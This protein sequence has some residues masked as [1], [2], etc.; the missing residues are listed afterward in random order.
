MEALQN[1]IRQL[2]TEAATK[3][4]MEQMQRR[5]D[6]QENDRKL[7]QLNFKFDKREAHAKAI[8]EADKREAQAKAEMDKREGQARCDKLE[9]NAKAE[10]EKR[11][12]QARCDKLEAMLEKEKVRAR[13]NEL[14]MKAKMDK[15]QAKAKTDMLEAAFENEKKDRLQQ[16]ISQLKWEARLGQTPQLMYSQPPPPQ[17]VYGHPPPQPAGHILANPAVLAPA[18]ILSTP[19]PIQQPI[20]GADSDS[21]V[22]RLK[23]VREMEKSNHPALSILPPRP[24]L[25]QQVHIPQPPTAI[26]SGHSGVPSPYHRSLRFILTP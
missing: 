3:Q 5:F 9:A 11:E 4:Q 8:A 7:E 10:A 15:R 12:T 22:Q 6:Q 16:Q 2:E 24:P 14:E 18:H 20:G 21:G 25:N 19:P 13:C 23:E 26:L 1:K 17:L